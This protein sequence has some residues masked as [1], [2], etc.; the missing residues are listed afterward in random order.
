MNTFEI[1]LTQHYSKKQTKLTLEGEFN[2]GGIQ[3]ITEKLLKFL[4]VL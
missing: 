3:H 1:R 2:R 4:Q